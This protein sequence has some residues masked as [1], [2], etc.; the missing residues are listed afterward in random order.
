MGL[1]GGSAKGS[2]VGPRAVEFGRAL[3]VD[4]GGGGGLPGG[5]LPRT[6]G[7][8]IALKPSNAQTAATR[9]RS[10]APRRQTHPTSRASTS[11]GLGSLLRLGKLGPRRLA[12]PPA[13]SE[14]C[15]RR[16]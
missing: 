12:S 6:K 4:R 5:S 13:L 15:R 11:R 2:S 14:V 9:S 16:L 1:L 7:A 10:L 8:P 3:R